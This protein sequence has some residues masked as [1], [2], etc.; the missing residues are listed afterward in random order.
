[1]YA[2]N[3]LELRAEDL[4]PLR[5]FY[6]AILGL[7]LLSSTEEE[8]T[9][10][11]GRSQLCFRRAE[12]AAPYHFA[13]N[14]SPEKIESAA[15]W[16]QGRAPLREAD[17]RRIVEFANWNAR[18]VYFTDPAGN[19]LEFIARHDLPFGD[20]GPFRPSD[21][22]GLSEIGV[23]VEDVPT[24]VNQ[25]EGQLGMLPYKGS[26]SPDF[27]ALGDHDGLLIVVRK[28]RPWFSTPSF[29]AESFPAK[30][31]FEQGALGKLVLEG[32]N[33]IIVRP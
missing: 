15:D 2:L 7:P 16:L 21:I 10:Q 29:P 23:V 1:L 6:T 17:G 22:L 30:I 11:A 25:I 12:E 14:I 18:A 13:F 32:T 9:F 8:V 19:I 27:A 5:D 20:G 24:A 28:G 31:E 3:R 26:P 4:G 33:E